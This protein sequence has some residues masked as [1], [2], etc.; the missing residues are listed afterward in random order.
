[1][2]EENIEEL[3]QRI[4]YL[5]EKVEEWKHRYNSNRGKMANY[6][7]EVAKEVRERENKLQDKERELKYRENEVENK[8]IFLENT[9]FEDLKKEKLKIDELKQKVEDND[10]I[11]R[12]QIKNDFENSKQK[13]I[14]ELS[15]ELIRWTEENDIDNQRSQGYVIG[16]NKAKKI[17]KENMEFNFA[18]SRLYIEKRKIL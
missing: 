1:M 14:D 2:K 6:K 4:E 16:I 15:K 13:I 10:Y 17:I 7:R 12:E 3:K 9:N 18:T 5:E 8:I 11:N